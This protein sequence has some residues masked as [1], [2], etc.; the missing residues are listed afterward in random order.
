MFI[1]NIIIILI[2]AYVGRR[3]IKLEHTYR[4]RLGATNRISVTLTD[5]DY[6][7]LEI[8]EV[9][10]IRL[11]PLEKMTRSKAVSYILKYAQTEINHQGKTKK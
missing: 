1:Y 10:I 4:R 7:R 11:Q 8:L 3:D 6:K 9:K 5:E 2:I